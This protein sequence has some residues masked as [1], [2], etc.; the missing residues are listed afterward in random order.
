[1]QDGVGAGRKTTDFRGKVWFQVCFRSLVM[2]GKLI[3]L[4]VPWGG[5]VCVCGKTGKELGQC[6]QKRVYV[7]GNQEIK[8]RE[9]KTI[10]SLVTK[11]TVFGSQ[12]GEDHAVLLEMPCKLCTNLG[13]EKR[14]GLCGPRRQ[15]GLRGQPT[16]LTF[17]GPK[18]PAP[19]TALAA[20]TPCSSGISSSLSPGQVL[21]EAGA[22]EI[23]RSVPP[24]SL[25]PRASMGDHVL[26]STCGEIKGRRHSSRCAALSL[27]WIRTDSPSS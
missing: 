5:G 4:P 17:S 20:P 10:T 3:I 6:W 15:P 14:A 16:A 13:R 11:L 21:L 8:G 7:Q 23:L 9:G 2:L 27:S 25:G 24:V 18:S 22:S 12:I 19:R 26:D 1:M